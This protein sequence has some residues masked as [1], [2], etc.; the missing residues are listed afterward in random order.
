MES[1]QTQKREEGENAE[2]EGCEHEDMRRKEEG[3]N[4]QGHGSL[5]A[6]FTSSGCPCE[7]HKLAFS[8]PLQL[9]DMLL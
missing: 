1:S 4:I 8:S 3:G 5:S 9:Q 6:S 2:T 7:R